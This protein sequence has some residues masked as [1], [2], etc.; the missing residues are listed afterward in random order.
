M[1]ILRAIVNH[2]W[3]T[4]NEV[5]KTL[6]LPRATVTRARLRMRDAGVLSAGYS[7][8]LDQARP[9]PVTIVCG[10]AGS[11][12]ADKDLARGLERLLKEHAASGAFIVEGGSFAG[13]VMEASHGR[14]PL[15][16]AS[17]LSLRAPQGGSYLI[18]SLDTFPFPRAPGIERRPVDFA[19]LLEVL[20]GKARVPGSAP[21]R[22]APRRQ[23]GR[24][25]RKSEVSVALSLLE[26]PELPIAEAARAAGLSRSTFAHVK[27]ALLARGFLQE[28]TWVRLP[29]I[30]FQVLLAVA[31]YRRPRRDDK[32]APTCARCSPKGPRLSRATPHPPMRSPSRRSA[33]LPPR[34]KPSAS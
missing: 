2:P 19:P 32:A 20:T 10:R 9:G 7:F 23:E 5:G 28:S 4:D 22:S 16:S 30:G 12:V 25:L 15:W 6:G 33:T 34:A 29:A 17:A 13:A 8:D 3:A 21:A 11:D 31:L 1:L 26:H 18:H 24:Q 27:G 14:L